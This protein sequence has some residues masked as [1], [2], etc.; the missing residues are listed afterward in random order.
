[1]NSAKPS[2]VWGENM[3]TKEKSNE[4]IRAYSNE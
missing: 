2:I 3:T 1:M 4:A